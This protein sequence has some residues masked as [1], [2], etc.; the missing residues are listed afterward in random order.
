MGEGDQ[1]DRPDRPHDAGGSGFASGTQL[2]VV[3]PDRE[4]LTEA[5]AR[6]VG[7]AANRLPRLRRLRALAADRI[8]QIFVG[9][10]YTADFISVGSLDLQAA[11]ALLIERDEMLLASFNVT[12]ERPA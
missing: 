1:R 11:L 4:P 8:G 3:V 2:P 9:S 5:E 10:G 7:T 12:I 6:R